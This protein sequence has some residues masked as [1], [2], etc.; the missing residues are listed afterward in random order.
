MI[1]A[2]PSARAVELKYFTHLVNS[3]KETTRSR[4]KAHKRLRSLDRKL[5]WL[6]AL[7]SAYVV[8]LTLAPHYLSYQE[9]QRSL[10]DLLTV[11]LSIVIIVSSLLQFASQNGV[12]AEQHHRCALEINEIRRELEFAGINTDIMP[13]LDRYRVALQK[14]SIN[15]E[16]IDYNRVRLERRHEHPEI[17]CFDATVLRMKLFFSDNLIPIITFILTCAFVYAVGHFAQPKLF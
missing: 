10:L 6:T 17:T 15:H 3:M 14:Y 13:Y 12:E 5:T 8:I 4:F 2:P 1:D 7:A 11:A 9:P 16:D